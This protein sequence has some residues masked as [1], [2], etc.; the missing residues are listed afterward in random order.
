L[1]ILFSENIKLKSYHLSLPS[2][3]KLSGKRGKKSS[4]TLVQIPYLLI[5][6]LWEEYESSGFPAGLVCTVIF[7]LKNP[8][9][10]KTF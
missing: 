7:P 5:V 1:Q 6:R 9:E 2:S 8:L 10:A 3:G 4:C